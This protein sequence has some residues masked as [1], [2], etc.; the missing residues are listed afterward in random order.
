[1]E[2]PIR[3]G[4]VGQGG[5]AY[6]VAQALKGLEVELVA[7]LDP[8]GEGIPGISTDITLESFASHNPQ[9]VLQ[10]SL[11]AQLWERFLSQRPP[12][13]AVMEYPAVEL[14]TRSIRDRQELLQAR[15]TQEQLT[16]IVNSAQEGIQLADRD[17]IIRYVNPAFSR[18][19]GVPGPQRIGRSVFDVSP[20]GALAR[21]LRLGKPVFGLRNKA[22]GS[23][24]EVISNASP[25]YVDG[26]LQGAVVVFQDLTD[27]LRM[28][29]QIQ[30]TSS[31]IKR[32]HQQ[33]EN[34]QAAEFTFE[35]VIG[36]SEAI[37]RAV[38][39]GK[40]VSDSDSTVLIEGETGTG[41]EVF[42]HAI[43]NASARRAGPF[44]RVNCAAI[45]EHLLESEIFGYEPGA[46]T[47]ANRTKLG[48]F[49]LAS[50]GTILLDEIGDMPPALQGKLLR[51]L[52][53][54]RFERLGGT[55]TIH[56]DVRVIAATNRNL[57]DRVSQGRFREDLFYRLNVL[58][59]KI[60]PL[61]ERK[62][63]IPDL[64]AFF[65]HQIGLQMGKAI[66]RVDQPAMDS[67]LRHRWPGN[68][69][70]LQNVLERAIM[71]AERDVISEVGPLDSRE[72]CW[73]NPT[74]EVLAL[75]TVEREM[76]RRAL[77]RFGRSVR[78]K[79]EASRYLNISL[80]TLYN[81]IKKYGLT[82]GS[83]S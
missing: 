36:R 22:V 47:G 59:L 13:C 25:I 45:P 8:S 65:L 9:L 41:K 66:A 76:I 48:R 30:E 69:R 11:D 27:V 50:G 15:E 60:P 29:R 62:E 80:A 55:S 1:M 53:E 3:V 38:D 79:R 23:K 43:H 82:P 2:S 37:R 7:V 64:A 63:D 52:Q 77:N 78:G 61:R 16:A 28:G 33:I 26:R 24:A 46:F 4:L 67:L 19:T 49:E 39:I 70:E 35:D 74:G 54:H 83:D 71:M 75:R 21:C 81:K 44:I 12:G 42:A 72:V 56:V 14:L 20:D 31:V 51:V 5:K 10:V 32:L 40:R 17:G 6:K 58:K 18:I 68:V 34:L 57:S 73:S